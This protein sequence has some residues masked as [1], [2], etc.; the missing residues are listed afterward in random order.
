MAAATT[1]LVRD[2][3]QTLGPAIVG[4]VALSLAA[5]QIASNLGSAGL[6]PAEHGT[7]SA[8]LSEG[9]PLALHTAG[10][11]PLRGPTDYFEGLS[12]SAGGGWQSS[13]GEAAVDELGSALD[14]ASAAD[15]GVRGDRQAV[16]RCK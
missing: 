3:G 1:S 4:A 2:L 5:T 10:L 13:S 9:G 12:L 8:V 11:G 16:A 14:V 7:A 15:P 6:A